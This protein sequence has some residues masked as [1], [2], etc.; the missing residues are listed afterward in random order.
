MEDERAQQTRRYCQAL[1]QMASS[2]A[3]VGEALTFQSLYF[4][5]AVTTLGG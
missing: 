1:D 2:L 3:S 4:V 5:G